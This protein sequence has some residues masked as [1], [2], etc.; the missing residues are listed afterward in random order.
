MKND[1]L[2]QVTS[3]SFHGHALGYKLRATDPPQQSKGPSLTLGFQSNV[4]G[5]SSCLPAFCK[6]SN[7]GWMDE[8]KETMM[9]VWM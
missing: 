8:C 6:Q 1:Q 2:W 9:T 4:V 5:L 7:K 3:A